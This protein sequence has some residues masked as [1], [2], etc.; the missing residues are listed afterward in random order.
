MNEEENIS[1]NV[2]E[3]IGDINNEE[4]LEQ[5]KSKFI[6]KNN[7]AETQWF[8]QSLDK[9]CINNLKI[10][11]QVKEGESKKENKTYN[12]ED[13]K[14]CVEFIEK[15]NKN[16]IFLVTL[17]L[18]T[19][20]YVAVGDLPRLVSKLKEQLVDKTLQVNNYE[21]EIIASDTIFR[22]IGA[23][24][25]SV[26]IAP[27]LKCVGF[28]KKAN[29]IMKIVWEQFPDLREV[30]EKWLISLCDQYDETMT[31]ETIQI[32][33]AFYQIIIL[34]YIEAEIRI[35]PYLYKKESNVGN[36]AFLIY[37]LYTN[38]D[39]RTFAQKLIQKIIEMESN[40]LW[41]S[42][43]LFYYMAIKYK[44]EI[45]INKQLKEKV[46]HKLSEFHYKDYKF[47]AEL[48][49]SQM[50]MRNF[51]IEMLMEKQ[52]EERDIIVA[53]YLKILRV[54]YYKINSKRVELPLVCCDTEQQ[55]KQLGN[56]V[57]TIMEKYTYRKELYILLGGYLKELSHYDISN[58]T[59]K[60]LAAYFYNLSL[61]DGIGIQEV[62]GFLDYCDNKV[63]TQVLQ[64]LQ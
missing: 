36:L 31:I 35:L 50:E 53:I 18:C 7:S 54:C 17:V 62:N 45:V 37:K 39:S 12:L 63:S 23:G 34:D 47:I 40:W 3:Q 10:E 8:I 6:A 16:K 15:N 38:D 27:E 61:A 28:G 60:H 30:I 19:F 29:K 4:E 41:K 20:Q 21:E 22:M 49:M 56:I 52:K 26:E 42:V 43:T 9:I 57:H 25:I 13:K 2:A 5:E 55:Q 51:I 44:K 59:V 24:F 48:L 46:L 33:E 11:Y 64:M 58:R 14:E 1:E 32:M